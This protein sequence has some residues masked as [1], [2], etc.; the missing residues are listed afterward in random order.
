MSNS[1]LRTAMGKT[2]EAS[3]PSGQPSYIGF[4]YQILATVWIGL[5]VTIT[6]TADELAVEPPESQED[7]ELDLNVPVEDADSGVRIEQIE[8]QIKYRSA[9]VWKSKEFGRLLNPKTKK[10][11]KGP[12]PR[13]RPLEYLR[14][15]TTRQYI[16]LTNARTEPTLNVFHI[17]EIGKPSAANRIPYG[18]EDQPDL[19]HRIGVLPDQTEEL[20]TQNI[21]L[22]LL[23][24]CH[25]PGVK[26][27]NCRLA[28][29]SDVR[30]RLKGKIAADFSKAAIFD[31]IREFGGNFEQPREPVQPK[32]Y[33]NFTD[34]LAK[35]H[36]LIIIGPPGTG[37][38]TLADALVSKLERHDPPFERREVCD[39]SGI[40]EVR[41]LLKEP[42]NHVFYFIDP[43]GRYTTNADAA[44]FT[45]ELPK[46]LAKAQPG[47][48]FIVTSPKGVFSDAVGANT[49]DFDPFIGHLT[50]DDYDKEAYRSIYAL[51][52]ENWSPALRKTGRRWQDEALK[53]IMT[54]LA[55][56]T[57][58][59]A[60]LKR[61]SSKDRIDA[62]V[63]K[64]MADNSNVEHTSRVIRDTF[65]DS[66][67]AEIMSVIAIWAHLAVSQ[68][69]ITAQDAKT[70]RNLLRTGGLAT[71]PDVERIFNQLVDAGWLK[72]CASE[73][74]A[75]A[76]VLQ[77][78]AQF[79]EITP[80]WF[81]DTIDAL[82]RGWLI[83]GKQNNIL[84]CVKASKGRFGIVPA[85]I[86]ASIDE[87]LIDIAKK[88]EAH[89]F[90]LAL[91]EIVQY[92]ST[93]HPVAALAR[94]LTKVEPSPPRKGW[95]IEM[96][97]PK[98]MKPSLAA[99]EIDQLKMGSAWFVEKFVTEYLLHETRSF[100][101]TVYDPQELIDFLNQFGWP[102]WN[103]FNTAFENSLRWS[104]DSAGF[105]TDCLCLID[106]PSLDRTFD[107][108][109]QQYQEAYRDAYNNPRTFD[110]EER[111]KEEQGEIDASRCDY[112]EPD[113]SALSTAQ[114]A[115]AAALRHRIKRD[116]Y[117]WISSHP[118][119]KYLLKPWS[120]LLNGKE[121]PNELSDF[122]TCCVQNG[123]ISDIYDALRYGADTTLVPI[124]ADLILK[125]TELSHAANSVAENYANLP[126]FLATIES[127]TKKVPIEQRTQVGLRLMSRH[128]ETVDGLLAHLL[129]VEEQRIVR[130][131][132]SAQNN[133]DQDTPEGQTAR[134]L[135]I[136]LVNKWPEDTAIYALAVL[137]RM[138]T[139]ISQWIERFTSSKDSETRARAWRLCADK[140][141]LLSQGLVDEDCGCRVASLE[142]L[143]E[144]ATHEEQ[145]HLMALAADKS[146]YVRKALAECIGN[147]Q[148][149]HG[150][151][152]LIGLLRD[153][154][155]F[156]TQEH[157]DDYRIFEV[158]RAACN[159]LNKFPQLP[160]TALDS[161]RSFLGEC[162]KASVDTTVHGMLFRI[163]SKYPSKKI[164]R[165]CSLYIKR[166]WLRSKWRENEG[167]DLLVQC[168]H[169]IIE[170]LLSTPALAA[171]LDVTN[172]AAIA[173]WD[174][175]DDD[176]VGAALTVIGVTAE[177]HEHSIDPLAKKDSFTPDRAR[178]LLA[179]SEFLQKT[180]PVLIT[181]HLASEE[182]FMKLLDW[183]TTMNRQPPYTEFCA[184]NQP[185]AEWVDSFKGNKD[186][187]SAYE[188]WAINRL[189]GTAAATVTPPL[190]PDLPHP[191]SF[192]KK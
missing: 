136:Y 10:G 86:Q 95:F 64:Q 45:S 168:L 76:T 124:V 187:V 1:T 183:A 12:P 36:A 29:M 97:P 139:D 50:G 128:I 43:W 186:G 23:R 129:P 15:N 39:A 24:D 37:K 48:V 108:C 17:K 72:P 84:A 20:L 94:L 4:E 151:S 27:N 114:S 133:R 100:H 175:D 42:D 103:W 189:I 163:L 22:I 171:H 98:W 77:A 148:W 166:I 155:E 26:L 115:L 164:I 140:A 180:R 35:Q 113:E 121:D 52:I 46:L 7:A 106:A 92:S 104:E 89:N 132:Y 109:L 142:N 55:V 161:I 154:R 173:G 190:S 111:R 9:P 75:H 138:G 162:T 14:S 68:L 188:R 18:R 120:D 8:I 87:H 184:A 49:S 181:Q 54:P 178:L 6:G 118:V 153:K 146:A 112:Y 59:N 145:L 67:P 34:R 56:G 85:G 144:R 91:N 172:I 57:F 33:A 16:L 131:C 62:T 58:C 66:D 169:S 167:R 21:D 160:E 47:K 185:V 88:A 150:V 44:T 110:D 41:R 90:V 11:Q 69:K 116:G 2:K 31:R 82:F 70:L 32:N 137:Q 80:G 30:E 93:Q 176:L 191:F 38:T 78:L 158:A 40:S 83:A 63:V 3:D 125:Q 122:I 177:N 65:K 105:L 74:I 130:A 107:T 79:E 25:V 71:P 19:A 149:P 174:A 96:N 152:P 192:T 165:F 170:I 143:A 102:I 147:K 135:L 127:E 28:L 123:A 134:A 126:E 179:A 156:G 119:V 182:P 61:L 159:A 117:T 101:G 99:S 51:G 60:L 157:A 81:E 53:H 13:V 73:N 5:H 141:R